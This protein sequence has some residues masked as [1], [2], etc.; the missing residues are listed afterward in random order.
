M[1]SEF[2]S[3]NLP[4]WFQL[5]EQ[6]I[7]LLESGNFRDGDFDFG[8]S[9]QL[10]YGQFIASRFEGVKKRF[11]SL[12]LYPFAR[13]MDDDDIACFDLDEPSSPPKV[14][15][16]H[17]F[18]SPGWEQRGTFENYEAWREAAESESMDD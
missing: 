12:N 2:K 4:D 9:W 8:P 15:I 7:K 17:D 1:N 3:K 18:A 11:P 5:P 10:L 14:V 6:Y 13:R 16:I